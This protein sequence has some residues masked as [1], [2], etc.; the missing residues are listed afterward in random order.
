MNG[1]ESERVI[2]SFTIG[3]YKAHFNAS[4][5]QIEVQKDMWL[6]LY[7]FANRR[8]GLGETLIEYT[9]IQVDNRVSICDFDLSCFPSESPSPFSMA[10]TDSVGQSGRNRGSADSVQT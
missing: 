8:G 10:T 3:A 2:A 9:K 7:S 4:I 5:R 1:S 6:C